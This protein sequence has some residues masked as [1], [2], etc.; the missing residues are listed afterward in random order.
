[1]SDARRNNLSDH[2]YETRSLL[3]IAH[4]GHELRLCGWIGQAKPLVCILTD[5]SGSDDKP[6]LASTLNILQDLGA[7]IG[8]VCG[9]F[10][11]RQIYQKM[12]QGEYDMFDALCERLARSSLRETFARWS[13][14]ASR[15]TTRR[16]IYARYLSELRWLLPTTSPTSSGLG[17][18]KNALSG[19]TLSPSWVIRDPLR[20][21]L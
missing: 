14:T 3:V 4:P 10:T 21:Q 13:A 16:T 6:R 15:V 1:M 8:P 18:E 2:L 19:I 5:G 9:E 17:M 12:L 11:D 7:E 20:N